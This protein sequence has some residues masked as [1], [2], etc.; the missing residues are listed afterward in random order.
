MNYTDL[1]SGFKLMGQGMLGIFIVMSVIYIIVYC[2][3][4]FSK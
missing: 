2:F 4:K 1:I 3:T